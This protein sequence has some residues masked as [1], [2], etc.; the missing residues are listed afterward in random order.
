M[1]FQKQKPKIVTFCKYKTFDN[2]KFRSKSDF[3][4]YKETLF[5]HFR[6]M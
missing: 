2:A 4:S 5:N 6:N 3:G 1:G